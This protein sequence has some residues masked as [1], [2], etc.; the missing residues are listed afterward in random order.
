MFYGASPLVLKISPDTIPRDNSFSNRLGQVSFICFSS[1]WKFVIQLLQADRGSVRYS[2]AYIICMKNN[3]LSKIELFLKCACFFLLFLR[4]CWRRDKKTIFFFVL[5]C[6]HRFIS[7]FW[8]VHPFLSRL[9]SARSRNRIRSVWNLL[10]CIC[11]ITSMRL[12]NCVNQR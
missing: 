9:N 10:R 3:S 4:V 11:Y 12:K 5:F 6:F 1:S 8:C 7:I 2:S